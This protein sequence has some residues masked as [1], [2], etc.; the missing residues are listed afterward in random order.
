MK[1]FKSMYA[2]YMEW[3]LFAVSIGLLVIY[4]LPG[5]IILGC[6]IVLYYLDPWDVET[7]KIKYFDDRMKCIEKIH[8]GDWIDLRSAEDVTLK[9]GEYH[10]IRLGVGMILPKGYEAHVLPRSSTPSK[11]GIMCANSMGI[12]DNSY[13]GDE[14]EWKFPAVAIRDT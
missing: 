7:I 13:S 1:K 6:S 12:I 8:V 3:L 14:D 4:P 10:L 11:F 9:A 2:F 5:F